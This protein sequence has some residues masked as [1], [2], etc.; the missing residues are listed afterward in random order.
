MP[1]RSS[2]ARMKPLSNQRSRFAELQYMTSTI[3]PE[4]A[5]VSIVGWYVAH[6]TASY[7]TW[8]PCFLL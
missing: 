8:P 2:S 1:G 7:F 5:R 4:S 3:S 6:G